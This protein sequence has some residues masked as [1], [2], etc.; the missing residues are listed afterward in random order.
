MKRTFTSSAGQ[1]AMPPAVEGSGH[2]V[3]SRGVA[4]QTTGVMVASGTAAV[5]LLATNVVAARFLGPTGRGQYALAVTVATIAFTLGNLGISP[6][7]TFLVARKVF[8]PAS[9]L[10]TTIWVSVIS[11]SAAAGLAGALVIQAHGHLLHGIPISYLLISLSAVP[12]AVLVLNVQG[13]FLGLERF[14]DYNVVT[15]VQSGLIFL[16]LT[17]ALTTAGAGV[18]GAV[19]GFAASIAVVS[20]VS[21]GRAYRVVGSQHFRASR[22]YARAAVRYGIKVH[23]SNVLSLL[24]YRVD[25]FIINL[26]INPASVGLYVIAVATAERI[27]M[28]SL[29]ASSVILPRVASERDEDVRR[30]MTPAVARTTLWLTALGA[31]VLFVLSDW[32][33]VALYSSAFRDAVRPLQLLLPGIVLF[34]PARVLAND[35]AGRGRPGVNAACGAAGL[36]ANVAL[37]VVL[38]PRYG[39][40]GA[41]IASTVSYALVFGLTVIAYCTLS[42]NSLAAIVLPKRADVRMAGDVVQG[43]R[44]RFLVRHR[45]DG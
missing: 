21:T 31:A 20:A 22:A 35:L 10:A 37:N 13:I 7:S 44:N 38:L 25:L 3:R 1:S 23:L 40:D 11:G 27:W 26:V 4:Q 34:A 24:G 17:F 43:M 29:A 2:S 14:G 6:A 19:V 42:R 39:V 15:V 30:A 41:S 28:L 32:L 36:T 33:V 5:L 45:L 16:S 12:F 8:P 9:A 18:S